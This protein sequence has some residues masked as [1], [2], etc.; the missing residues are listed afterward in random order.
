MNKHFKNAISYS[1]VGSLGLVVISAITGCQNKDTQEQAQNQFFV[2]VEKPKD[3][4]TVTEQYPTSGPSR[5]VLRDINGK[6]RVITQEQMRQLVQDD[7]ENV[8]NGT[9]NLTNQSGGGLSLGETLMAAAG[10]ALLGSL[11]GNAL[12]NN[13]S[14]NKNF[15]NRQQSAQR[16]SGFSRN[17]NKATKKT[18][19]RTSRSGF[20]S[21]KGRSSVRRGGFFGG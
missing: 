18:A 12:A 3:Q 11:I 15:Q 19:S 16:K 7:I 1:S 5:A 2:I 13:L 9:S 4:Y 8:K 20:F 21:S 6:E 17:V 10:G 14:K